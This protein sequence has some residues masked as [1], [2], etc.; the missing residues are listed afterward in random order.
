MSV[1]FVDELSLSPNGKYFAT[2]YSPASGEAQFERTFALSD[3]MK[4]DP[5]DDALVWEQLGT[6][7]VRSNNSSGFGNS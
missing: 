3:G 4:A 1:I 2:A 6:D 7:I 5:T